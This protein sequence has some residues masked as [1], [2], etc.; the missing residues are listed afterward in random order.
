MEIWLVVF[1]TVNSATLAC[2]TAN[3][4]IFDESTPGEFFWAYAYADGHGLPEPSDNSWTKSGGNSTPLTGTNGFQTPLTMDLPSGEAGRRGKSRSEAPLASKHTSY[5][6]T[7]MI[8]YLESSRAPTKGRA[9]REVWPR[10]IRR[11]MARAVCI[12]LSI[13]QSLS[14]SLSLSIYI[15]ICV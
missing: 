10:S 13:D 15:Y 1:C 12:Y 14:L 8:H 5:T 6:R 7:R 3:P 2:L 9:R 11:V 4:S